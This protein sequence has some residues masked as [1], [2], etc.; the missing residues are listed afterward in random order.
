MLPALATAGWAP[1]QIHPQ[2]R[3]S[4]GKITATGR[5]HTHGRPLIADYVLEYG[6]DLPIAVV[7]AKRTRVAVADGVEQAKRYAERLDLP[8]A[9]ATN[10][11]EIY[12]I[13]R[14]TGKHKVISAFPSPE[15]LWARYR[16][17]QEI[18]TD[19]GVTLATTP[20]N[21][22]LRNPL[23]NTPKRPRYYQRL[24]VNKAVN[25]IANGQKRVLLTLATGTGKTM[26]AFQ[27][28]SK[29]RAASWPHG[30]RPPVVLYLADRDILANQPVND[31]F[32]PVFDDLVQ[33]LGGRGR[34]RGREIYFALYQAM[35][36]GETPLY[37]QFPR[38][39][40]DLVIVDECH[41]GSA[42]ESSQWRAILEYFEPAVQI[43]MT[44]T[45]IRR[46]DADT[47]NYFGPPVYEYSLAQGIDDGYLAP[48]RV[49][50]VR[51]N[52]D[53]TGYQ[54]Q[55]GELDIYGNEIPEGLY[56]PA[57]FERVMVLL[58]RTEAA[59]R[60]LTRYLR[61]TD[62]MAKTIVF[63]ENN[64][65]AHRMRQALVNQNADL[66]LDNY[67]V[68]ITDADGDPGKVH[69]D[70]FKNPGRPEPVIAVT[71]RLLSTGVDLPPVR[72]IV[73]F[74]RIASVSE[75][76]QTIG[77][78][79][80]LCPDIEKG[81]FDIIDFVE[82]TLLF[83]D[84]DF[85]GPPLA[86]QEDSIDEQGD[87]IDSEIEEQAE[88]PLNDGEVA[89]PEADYSS[90]DSGTF[91]PSDAPPS[92][93]D[94]DITDPDQVDRIRSQR[95]RYVQDGVEVYTWG[96]AL[97]VLSP[98]NRRLAL[99][100]YRQFVHDRVREL[101]LS[102]GDLLTQWAAAKSRKVLLEALKDHGIEIEGLVAE[103]RHPEVD[104]VDL[105]LNAAW[106]LPLVSRAERAAR[107]RRE[108]RAFLAAF[109]PKAS[110]VLE[111]LLDKFEEYGSIE[112]TPQALRVP[113]LSDLGSP[114]DLS[115]RFGGA[116]GL[117]QAIDDL[118]R[119]ILDVA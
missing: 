56:T 112:L 61:S 43:G 28:V 93:G 111:A 32:R 49:R 78:G 25:A 62:R 113:P 104:P 35:D 97:Y 15:E 89:E 16:S 21:T 52:V 50:R 106:G 72:N 73:I 80:R 45:P 20:F 107:V 95:P 41:R 65:H 105:L 96:D 74:R 27:I 19:L 42:R 70:S 58:D 36:H 18:D 29:L 82:A 48:Y 75:F 22:D 71:S 33:R 119:R 44:A 24:A 30:D 110:E 64:D 67:V 100:T 66:G 2:Y 77:R 117:S 94:A 116:G 6:T 79:T 9:Y 60:Y 40:F 34:T 5:Y 17:H 88:D 59:A 55:P 91:D 109:E 51:L 37:Q 83:N 101:N 12:E 13:D 47:Y 57:Q 84:P 103:L 23:D 7:E 31:Y 39:Y 87:L 1:A 99:I 90:Q 108:H 46:G 118:G 14:L 68:R 11:L 86:I 3:I 26:V 81:A 85:D 92:G 54:S 102:P 38:D 8:F 10:G 114:R 63:C 76:K 4:A 69:L 115:S 53:M 98:D